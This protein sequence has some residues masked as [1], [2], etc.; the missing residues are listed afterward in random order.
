MDLFR[1]PFAIALILSPLAL[2]CESTPSA[3]TA[4]AKAERAA[5]P[6]D[7][8]HSQMPPTQAQTMEV[9]AAADALERTHRVVFGDRT[10]HAYLLLIETGRIDAAPTSTQL[11]KLITTAFPKRAESG[12]LALLRKLIVTETDEAR[13][14]PAR[15]DFDDPDALA[16][17][18]A[19][20]RG[21]DDKRGDL[22]GLHVQLLDRDKNPGLLPA[23]ALADPIATRDLSE[24]ER[25]S[26]SGRTQVLLLR[27]DYRN[28]FDVRG[29]RLLQ[30]LVRLVALEHDALIFD[31]DTLET[32]GEAS[33]TERRLTAN[34]ANVVDQVAIIPFSD[35]DHEGQVR[36]VTRGMRRFGLPDLELSGLPRKPEQLQR[37]S[38]LIAGL[39]RGLIREAEVDE[40]GIA[41]EAP[42]VIEVT[43]AD[44]DAAYA[45]RG[46]RLPPRCEDCPGRTSVH[47]VRR[48]ARDTD[49]EEHLTVSVQAP[50]AEAEAPGH[51]HSLWVARGL[52]AL[53]GPR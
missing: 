24:T 52:N 5:E 47:L 51:N 53:F 4:P 10:S 3:A 20:P 41:I 12:E 15:L 48:P 39:A 22:L 11:D 13:L 28:Q 40:S 19:L 6:E 44:V 33:F 31:P 21:P 35:P 25:A 2:G 38:D 16:D 1:T 17:A 23:D 7:Q 42:E 26:I 32:R 50:R 43:R 9:D 30:A 46:E 37:G 27:A 36:L 8:G 29:L 14:D 45:N 18:L 34:L 49:T